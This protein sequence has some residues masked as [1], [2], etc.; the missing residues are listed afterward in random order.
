MNAQMESRFI[1]ILAVATV[2]VLAAGVA[3]FLT[4]GLIDSDTWQV[5]QDNTRCF[6]CCPFT[7]FLMLVPILVIDWLSERRR[8]FNSTRRILVE[9]RERLGFGT[10]RA[11]ASTSDSAVKKDTR[12]KLD[13]VVRSTKLILVTW[14]VALLTTTMC[15]SIWFI[16]FQRGGGPNAR[17]AERVTGEFL[18]ALHR[19]D[20]ETAHSML[21]EDGRLLISPADL[22][23]LR[24]TDEDLSITQQYQSLE[25]CEFAILSEEDGN[26]LAAFGLLHYEDG[27][28][29]FGS[30]MRRE[31]DFVWRIYAF[32]L[33]PDLDT[34]PWGR[35]F[36]RSNQ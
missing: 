36:F 24:E 27:T 13:S 32:E 2:I 19:G 7:L 34:T 8:L 29:V 22:D 17:T 23:Y 5:I 28:I 10:N 4:S 31:N 33:F 12:L 14:G 9:I 26:L 6:C 16:V 11:I 3:V 15:I 20:T 30:W 25:V 21:V 35:C 1:K 18:Q